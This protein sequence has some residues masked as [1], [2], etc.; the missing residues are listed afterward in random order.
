MQENS[1][2]VGDHY[3]LDTVSPNVSEQKETIED[4]SHALSTEIDL[5]DRVTNGVC[6]TRT[7]DWPQNVSLL[8][9]RRQSKERYENRQY[10]LD[11]PRLQL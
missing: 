11:L 9:K 1:S 8:K 2:D 4:N 6:D 7:L 5:S 3:M 10:D